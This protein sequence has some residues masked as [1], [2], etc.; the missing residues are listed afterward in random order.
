LLCHVLMV[1]HWSYFKHKLI[2]ELL[3]INLEIKSII[4]VILLQIESIYKS[5]RVVL[6]VLAATYLI[7]KSRAREIE[8]LH[9]FSNI[10]DLMI[11]K[12]DIDN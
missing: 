4:Q 8:N 7:T 9:S 11:F 5:W 1:E 6:C 3:H 2:R 10:R 12:A